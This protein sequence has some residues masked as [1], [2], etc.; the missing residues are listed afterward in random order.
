MT[1][2]PDATF[3]QVNKES[4]VLMV[5]PAR[6]VKREKEVKQVNQDTTDAKEQEASPGC[7]GKTEGTPTD[8]AKSSQSEEGTPIKCQNVRRIP[9]CSGRDSLMADTTAMLQPVCL[10]SVHVS[11]R[12]YIHC[13]N[14][15]L[16][17]IV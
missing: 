5:I 11:L 16:R 9:T 7:P 17:M 1:R 6:E 14:E 15:R 12:V 2:F 13:G 3:P 10:S 8:A 4:L